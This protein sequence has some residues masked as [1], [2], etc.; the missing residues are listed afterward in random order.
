MTSLSSG[1]PRLVRAASFITYKERGVYSVRSETE[2][3]ILMQKV[4]SG[5]RGVTPSPVRRAI[6]GGLY[7][8]EEW[9][10]IRARRRL[11]SDLMSKADGSIIR[12]LT[13]TVR[14]ND[15]PNYYM[16]YKDLFLRHIYRFTVR[17]PKPLILDCGSNIGMSILYFKHLC[18]A[19]RVIGFEPDPSIQPYLFENLSRNTLSDVTIVRGALAAKEGFASFHSGDKYGSCLADHAAASANIPARKTEV[20]PCVRLRDYLTEPVDF[21]KMNIEGAEYDVLADCVDRLQVVSEMVIEYHHLP[22][23]PR[24]LHKLL[25]LLHEHGFEILINDF[26]S[27]TN[28]GTVPPFTLVPDSR[29]FLLIY[30]R[31]AVT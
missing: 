22:G 8:L 1:T 16:L 18:P 26:D 2:V 20:V 28:P 12:L 31:R 24:T 27:E 7:D 9:R 6:R 10:S 25:A 14:I 15:G 13:Y 29:Y 19:A 5:L 11:K 4:L 17:R 30:A 23:L 3:K 21:L